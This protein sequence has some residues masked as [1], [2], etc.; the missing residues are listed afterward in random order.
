MKFFRKN[1]TSQRMNTG[2]HRSDSDTSVKSNDINRRTSNLKKKSRFFLTFFNY[3]IMKSNSLIIVENN[4]TIVIN[5]N[6]R[7]YSI[8]YVIWKDN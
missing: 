3:I 4:E 5:T 8:Q 1:E 2:Q 7:T 6:L